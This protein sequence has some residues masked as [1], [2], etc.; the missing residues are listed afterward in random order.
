MR[1]IMALKPFKKGLKYPGERLGWVNEDLE[2]IVIK[3]GWRTKEET[4][5]L[6]NFGLKKRVVTAFGSHKVNYPTIIQELDGTIRTATAAEKVAIRL[7][8]TGRPKGGLTKITLQ[9]RV[10]YIIDKIRKPRTDAIDHLRKD[11][12]FISLADFVERK[13]HDPNYYMRKQTE[14]RHE[15]NKDITKEAVEARKEAEVIRQKIKKHTYMRAY[16]EPR[17][18]FRWT[19][20]SERPTNDAGLEHEDSEF[21]QQHPDLF[22]PDVQKNW[23][24]PTN[25][26][27]TPHPTT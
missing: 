26:I 1:Q 22:P 14:R 27:R 18:I 19:P 6:R 20:L 24:G 13:R 8:I 17:G 25:P 23:A 21:V 4:D 3:E 9:D 11:I 5:R 16:Y 7:S 10:N 15:R 12:K 2:S